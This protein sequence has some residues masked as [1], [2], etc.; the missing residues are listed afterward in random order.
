[1]GI[2]A[3]VI[4]WSF[5]KNKIS[6]QLLLGWNIVE[7]ALVLFILINGILSAKF[8]FQQFGFEQPNRGINYFPF[9][10][11]PA[12]IVPIVIWTHLSDI[13]KLRKKKKKK[14]ILKN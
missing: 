5:L 6:K 8:P 2:T 4:G 7:L 1:M 12:T 9:V 14:N 13:I 3:P 10:L 11:L